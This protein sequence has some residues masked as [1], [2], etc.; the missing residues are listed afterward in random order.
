MNKK[1]FLIKNYVLATSVLYLDYKTEEEL[2]NRDPGKKAI[3]NKV[4]NKTINSFKKNG[5][6]LR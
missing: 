2:K 3:I 1:T 4:Q 5:E 6:S